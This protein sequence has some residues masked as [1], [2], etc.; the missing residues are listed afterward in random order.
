MEGLSR[1]Q[2]KQ[3]EKRR[4]KEAKSFGQFAERWFQDGSMAESTKA[5]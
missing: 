2:E 4:L 1:A 3:R 5:M